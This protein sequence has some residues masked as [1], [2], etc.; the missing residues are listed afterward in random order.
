MTMGEGQRTSPCESPDSIVLGPHHAEDR[1]SVKKET[2][3]C[4]P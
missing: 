3:I 4:S 2:Y 1:L